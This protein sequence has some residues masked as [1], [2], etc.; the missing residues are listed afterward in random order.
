MEIYLDP[1][2]IELIDTS[3]LYANIV[4]AKRIHFIF[5]LTRA[6]RSGFLPGLIPHTKELK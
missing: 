5:A 2:N 1:C 4:K 6:L 3:D